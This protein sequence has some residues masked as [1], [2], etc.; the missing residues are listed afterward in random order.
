MEYIYL[1]IYLLKI[2]IKKVFMKVKMISTEKIVIGIVVIILSMIVVMF[3]LRSGSDGGNVD[4]LEGTKITVNNIEEYIDI[5]G[6]AWVTD[7]SYSE[8][9]GWYGDGVASFTFTNLRDCAYDN[10]EITIRM[11]FAGHWE[12]QTVTFKLPSTGNSTKNVS[13]AANH[14]NISAGAV[15]VEIKNWKK[16]A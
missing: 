7:W 2:R 1:M 5:E 3:G 15:I 9:R 13:I 11:E 12:N 16:R 4:S 10:L 14:L 6:S 8:S